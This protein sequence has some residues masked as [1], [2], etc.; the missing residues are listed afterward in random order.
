MALR[1]NNS[2]TEEECSNLMKT[3]R[4]LWLEPV[5]NDLQDPDN[6]DFI[7]LEFRLRSAYIKLDSDFRKEAPG[8]TSLCSNLA[9]MYELVSNKQW[10]SLLNEDM[11][12]AV[13][14]AA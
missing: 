2:K 5:L 1:E 7:V 12:I 4:S 10:N 11:I 9:Y 6:N 3:L 8:P 14:I 13:V